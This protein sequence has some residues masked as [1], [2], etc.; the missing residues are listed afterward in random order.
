M[1]DFALDHCWFRG[2][3]AKPWLECS[4]AAV[5]SVLVAG[6]GEAMYMPMWL[7]SEGLAGTV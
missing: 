4:W 7:Q 6:R 2:Q 1:K 3:T 5:K